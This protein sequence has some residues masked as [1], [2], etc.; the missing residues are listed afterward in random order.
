MKKTT[1]TTTPLNRTALFS[2]LALIGLLVI[3]FWRSFLPGIVHFSNDGPLGQ[4][5]VNFTKM[6][7]SFSG[8]WDDLND[9]GY[10]AGLASPSISGLLT[11][12]LTPWGHAKFLAPIC[13]LILGLGALSFFRALKLSPLAALLGAAAAMFN[14][15]W[16]G[17]ICWG[18]ASQGI[19]LGMIF[20]ALAL[21]VSTTPEMRPFIRWAR[22][23]LAG[24]CVG[25]SVMDGADVAALY[26]FILAGFVLVRT[27]AETEEPFPKKFARGVVRVAVIAAFAFIIAIQ[28]IVS[29]YSTS[30]AGVAGAG[31]DQQ[32]KAANWDFATQW[33]LPKAETLGLFVPGLFGYKMDTPNGMP[34]EFKKYYEGGEYW[35]GMGRD[36]RNDRYFDSGGESDPPVPGWLRQTGNQNYSGIL[37]FLVGIWAAAQA[38]RRKDSPFTD[39]QKYLVFFWVF[40]AAISLPI[41]WGR[42]LPGSETSNGFLGYAFLYK[43]PYFS[44]IRNPSKFLSFFNLALVMLFAYGIDNL[45]RR[46]LGAVTKPS[47]FATLFDR[48]W[49]YFCIALFGAGALGWLIYY[50]QQPA[51]I[52][53]L[54]KVGF[55]DE[56]MASQIAGFSLAQAG[57]FVALLAVAIIL[58][59]LVTTN[60]FTGARAKTGAVLLGVFLLFD[61]VRA[62]LPYIIHWDYGY[63]IEIGSLNPI[64]QFLADKPYEHRVHGLEFDSQQQLRGYDNYFGGMGL[65]KIEWAQHHFPY[66]NI[67]SIDLIQ[68]PRV[69]QDMKTYLEAFVPDGTLQSLP[70][71]AR[72][73]E[74]SNTRYLLGYTTITLPAPFGNIDTLAFLNQVLDPVQHRFQFAK[75]FDMVA[76][77]GVGRVSGLSDLTAVPSDDGQV[78]VIEFTGALPRARLYGNWQ[79]NTNDT[80]NLKNLTDINFDPWKTVLI[81]TPE[82]DLPAVA[83]NDNS[84]TVEFKDYAPKHFTLNANATTPSVLLVNDKYDPSWKVSVDGKPADLLRC[85][86][87]MRGVSVPAGQHTVVFDY[88]LPNTPLYVTLAGLVMA[89]LLGAFLLVNWRT[90]TKA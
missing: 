60:F 55:G 45:S 18:V 51:F 7:A 74:L 40:I 62:N 9:V 52:H 43:L 44:T 79:V 32:S 84:G 82:K 35:G 5:S 25:L 50:W 54:Q 88:T 73:W 22:F 11:W 29:I 61:L 58:L 41:A 16:F 47:G 53:Y 38:F 89:V 64:L 12:V 36:P 76:K 4:I 20:F 33:S 1:A 24:L 67:Q 37:V 30:V 39:K 34:S 6:P 14:S 90:K 83:T 15:T 59:L 69:A 87:Y 80:D 78:A 19:A 27:L 75:R 26:S 49:F 77:P 17:T 56:S 72:R 21:I 86:F 46:F 10:S 48:R 70:K 65:Y 57:W 63:K 23:A 2:A 71:L 42:F 31:Q 68:M 81:S 8:M 85:N 28:T 3:L 13:I 66:Y